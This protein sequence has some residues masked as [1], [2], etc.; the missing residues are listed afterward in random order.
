MHSHSDL[1]LMVDGRGLSKVHQGVTTEVTGYC[2]SSPA[3]LTDEGAGDV[4]RLFG[5]AGAAVA[6]LP[7]DWR[8]F[9]EYLGR[10]ESGGL[11][12]NVV[13][14]AGHT[15]LR[16]VGMGFE[17]RPPTDAELDRMRRLL[18]EALEDGAWGLSTGLIYPPSSYAE[19]DELVALAEVAAAHGG[20]YF[21][22]IRGEGASLI[23][24]VGEACEIGE[25]AGLPVQIA[26]HKA[27]GRPYWGRTRESLQLIDWA[28]ERGLDVAFDVYPCTAG[29]SSL[30]S[31]IPAWAHEGGRPRLLERLR[32]PAVRERLKAEGP[33]MSREFDQTLIARV[34]TPANRGCEGLTVAQIAEQR[35]LDPFETV[36]DLLIEEDGNVA[37]IFFSMDEADV[38]RVLSHPRAMIGSDGTAV[39]PEG[40]LSEGKPH[41]RFYGTFPQVL[42][43]YARDEGLFSQEEA[44]YKMAGRPA[45][46]LG[47][48]GKGRVA[49]GFDADLVVY[50]PATV[51]ERGTFQDPHHFPSGLPHVI[52]NGGLTVRDG[53]HTGAL[54]GRVLRR[55]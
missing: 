38:R 54:A 7:W 34:R 5:H 40:S 24:A 52:V 9:G 25:R 47:L 6:A 44:V 46:R 28:N 22:H 18:G 32:D 19:T 23:K 53:R 4:A 2:G 26:H 3:P 43:H 50:D 36:F 49:P 30:T 11:G 13:P 1:T 45:E 12:I 21:S 20:F 27:S 35:G 17:R 39:A 16:A 48:A 51:A 10:L 41:P 42:G 55:P 37:A 29:S 33:S 14:L 31:V 15:A 8:R